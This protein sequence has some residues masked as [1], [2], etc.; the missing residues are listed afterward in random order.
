ML[1]ETASDGPLLEMTPTGVAGLRTRLQDR[2]GPGRVSVGAGITGANGNLEPTPRES[3]RQWQE[4][5][6]PSDC[7]AT[8][9]HLQPAGQG[10]GGIRTNT[11][12]N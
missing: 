9:L 3:V 7:S 5:P 1:L 2:E 12:L 10:T 4:L 6:T 11:N 8:T